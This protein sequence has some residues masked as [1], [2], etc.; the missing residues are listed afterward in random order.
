MALLPLFKQAAVDFKV[1][2][3]FFILMY[4]KDIL[5]DG[6]LRSQGLEQ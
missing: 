6:I 2:L 3:I 1:S 4:V 5:R